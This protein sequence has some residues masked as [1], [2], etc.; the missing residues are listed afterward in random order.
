MKRKIKYYLSALAVFLIITSTATALVGDV[1]DLDLNT[2]PDRSQ[3]GTASE[4]SVDRLSDIEGTGQVEA[5]IP[6]Q[7]SHHH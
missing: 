5:Y 6:Y 7:G 3:S 1:G 4:N 2:Q